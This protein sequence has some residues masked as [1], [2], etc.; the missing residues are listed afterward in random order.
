MA[1][2]ISILSESSGALFGRRR[3]LSVVA[4]FGDRTTGLFDTLIA[5]GPDLALTTACTFG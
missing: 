4:V 5:A 1:R 3:F 2:E